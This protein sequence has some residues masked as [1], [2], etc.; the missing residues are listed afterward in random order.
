MEMVRRIMQIVFI[1]GLMMLTG[2]AVTQEMPEKIRDLDFTVVGADEEPQALVDIISEKKEEPFQMS[3][4]LGEDLY[5]VV[6][7]GAQ[8]L[9][10]YS[11]QVNECYE[12]ESSIFV[13]TTLLGPESQEEMIDTVTYPYI[14]IKMEFIDKNVVFQ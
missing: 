6:G 1:C 10:G 4:T 5:I 8:E 12:T 11:I 9:G 14:V 3:Y 2:C 7:Y 13:D